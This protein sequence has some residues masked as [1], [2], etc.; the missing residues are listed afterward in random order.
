MKNQYF[1]DIN[2]YWKYALLRRLPSGI[3]T[4][5]CW[6]LTPDD[7]GPDGRK[8]AYLGQSHKYRSHD[9]EL[10]DFLCARVAQGLRNVATIEESALVPNCNFYSRI[11]SDSGAER[12]AYFA[13]LSQACAGRELVF[14]DP[15]NGLE[16]NSVRY[17][18]KHSA[19][20][21][22]FQEI[23]DLYAAG[24]SL[25]IFQFFPRENHARYIERRAAELRSFCHGAAINPLQTTDV[26]YF[27]V[28]HPDSCLPARFGL[29]LRVSM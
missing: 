21:L 9:P 6:M 25:L 11:L 4:T 22:Y 8:L 20:Y 28:R 15:D 18:R 1:G 29:E 23:A 10:Y 5:V 16:V 27:L 24:L 3:R 7:G 14:F 12:R 26:V 2:D 19:R 13:G 17:G